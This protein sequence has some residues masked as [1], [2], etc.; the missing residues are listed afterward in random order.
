MSHYDEPVTTTAS[1]GPLSMPSQSSLGS[2]LSL[3]TQP[4]IV[5]GPN[6]H[7]SVRTQRGFRDAD[8]L[9]S[10]PA[11]APPS[12]LGRESSIDAH[13]SPDGKISIM[14]PH[15][16]RQQSDL[17]SRSP[18]QLQPQ[19]TPQPQNQSPSRIQGG[20]V[21]WG[22]PTTTASAQ[23]QQ[24]TFSHTSPRGLLPG[25]SISMYPQTRGSQPNFASSGLP[26]HT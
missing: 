8:S 14:T 16:F 24:Q 2:Q 22:S 20:T 21:H 7:I 18:R 11:A 10:V 19:Q 23:T 3:S 9:T 1:L 15:G 17:S 12:N 25:A 5:A 13:V 26:P 6:Q 4:D